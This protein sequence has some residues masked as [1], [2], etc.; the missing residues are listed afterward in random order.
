MIK[1]LR[2]QLTEECNFNCVYCCNEGTKNDYSI[3]KNRNL[4]AF[5]RA[6]HDVLGIKRVKFTGGEPL[7]YDEDLCKLIRSVDRPEI[8]YSIVTNATD[9]S[10]C[11]KL[12][13]EFPN[14]EVTISLPVPPN[15]KNISVFKQITG[16][17]HEKQAFH[18]IINSIEYLL[19]T[20]SPFKIN[21]VLCRDMNTSSDY[22]KEMIRYAQQHPQLQLRFLETIINSTNNKNNRMSRFVFTQME[23]E[24]I[25]EE[26]GY[27]ES[28]R[29]K[30]LDKRSSCIYDL[31]GCN[32]KFIKSFCNDNCENCPEDKTSLWL[33]STG[34]VKKCAY[35]SFSM[36]I[37]NWLYNRIAL[38][39]SEFI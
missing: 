36:P 28:V 8:Q 35:R 9:Y 31:N 5:I 38:Q 1:T 12:V 21:Y 33:T 2:I 22:I 3:L 18:N 26:L 32:I 30:I 24:A 4:E 17:I 37:E 39:L 19:Q 23:F 15:E 16:A 34:C 27:G 6:S 10:I 13:D 25:L 14:T 11:R 20:R 7:E 29:N